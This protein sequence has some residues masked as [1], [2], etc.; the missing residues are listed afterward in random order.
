M[1]LGSGCCCT[2]KTIAGLT[3]CVS[4]ESKD[5]NPPERSERVREAA[6]AALEHCLSCYQEKKEE[7]KEPEPVRPPE[8]TSPMPMPQE[9]VGIR[10]TAYYAR[11]ESKTTAQVVAD[12]R[13]VMQRNSRSTMSIE[14]PRG[15]RH[16]FGYL[17]N[18][19]RGGP[20]L[21]I[22]S[23]SKTVAEQPI[24]TQEMPQPPVNQPVGNS[25]VRIIYAPT[26]EAPVSSHPLPPAK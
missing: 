9:N 4:G 20:T 22:V 26:E 17:S 13:E 5:G 7:T 3:H 15:E 12:A 14:P 11:L 8:R 24:A 18:A 1:A 16:L 23:P 25:R 21:P 2:K 6:M 10:L 19:W